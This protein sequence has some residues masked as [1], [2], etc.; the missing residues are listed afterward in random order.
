MKPS[1][2]HVVPA[3][4][5]YPVRQRRINPSLP[6]AKYDGSSASCAIAHKSDDDAECASAISRRVA[7][8]ACLQVCPRKSEGAGNAGC[9]LAPAVSCARCTQECAHEH[10]GTAG[11]ARHSLRNG[12]TA[13]AELSLETNSSCLHR[14]RIDGSH[15]P[16]WALQTSASLTPATGART[17]RFCRTQLPPPNHSASQCRRPN[18]W[19]KRLSA[20]RL[21][22]VFAHG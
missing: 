7:P 15:R 21:R 16:G 22:A 1:S 11:A 14:R 3:H 18:F 20:V 19:R 5:G 8:E 4:A 9:R 13:Y 12:F 6:S 10:T 2:P 17:T